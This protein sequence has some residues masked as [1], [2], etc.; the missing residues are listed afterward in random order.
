MSDNIKILAAVKPLAYQGEIELQEKWADFQESLQT[1]LQQSGFEDKASAEDLLL[2]NYSHPVAAISSIFTTLKKLKEDYNE[3]AADGKAPLLF[4]IHQVQQGEFKTPLHNPNLSFWGLLKPENIYITRALKPTWEILTNKKQLP[5]NSIIHEGEGY[6]RLQ[7]AE[8]IDIR[9]ETLL[10]FRSLPVQGTGKECFYCG[11]K[12]HQAS[13]CP[14]RLLSMEID[15]IG[16]SGYIPFDKINMIYKAVFSNQDKYSK[17]LAAGIKPGDIRK[18]PGLLIYLSFFDIH[19]IYQHRFLWHMAFSALAKWDASFS[20][21]KTKIDNANLQLGLDCLRVH[22]YAQAEELL[23]R[24]SQ[25][26]APKRYYATIGLAFLALERGRLADMRNHLEMAGNLA[27][28]EKERIYTALLLSRYYDLNN[29]AWKARDLIKNIL[30]IKHDCQETL[31]RR[32]Q[33]E[34]R[35]NFTEDA[36]QQLRGLMS[37]Q[38]SFYM[39]VFMDPALLPIQAKVES[40]LS[41]QYQALIH[42]AR[43]NLVNAENDMT[44]LKLWLDDND[45]QMKAN[46]Q[47]LENLRKRFERKS[48]Y[49]V[50]D[51]DTKSKALLSA[52]KQL[53]EQKLNMVY[54]T[55]DKLLAHW[56]GYYNFWKRYKFQSLFKQFYQDLVPLKKKLQQ[57][58]ALAKQ[59]QGE[60]YRQAIKQLEDIQ[61]SLSA[62]KA[63]YERMNTV[64]LI[65]TGA[66]IFAKKLLISEV[67]VVILAVVI[68][69]TLKVI[70]ETT[71]LSSLTSLV[72]DPWFQKRAIIFL[73]ILFSPFIAFSWTLADMNRA[74]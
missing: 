53:R 22:Q 35:G 60:S 9:A 25:A 12:T 51:V 55:A 36:F 71:F 46:L 33:L 48:Y 38:R 23:T 37:G 4:V 8:N 11:M 52:G 10:S 19:R 61:A 68:G 31:Y 59:N 50:L 64:T 32:I 20:A 58:Q 74:G 70:P 30:T 67:A 39:A 69:V 13:A 18:D 43:T 44:D 40:V 72:N 49:D 1:L 56:N 29:E 26:R 15:S 45:P 54:D 63:T 21:K 27:I 34:V 73:T 5:D 66:C 47:T 6:Y 62:L 24:E 16:E 42:N 14:S 57:T 17:I 41:S 3:V 7:F 28:Q 65:A 2:F